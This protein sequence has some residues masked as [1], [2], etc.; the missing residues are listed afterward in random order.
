MEYALG[1]SVV[2]NLGM[3][4]LLYR[5]SKLYTRVT[6]EREDYK[7][8]VHSAEARVDGL[9]NV[10][11]AREE[12]QRRAEEELRERLVDYR[13][14]INRRDERIDKLL[15]QN[16]DMAERVAS[17][18]ASG[19]LPEGGDD[20]FVDEAEEPEPWSEG[21]RKFYDG[22]GHEAQ[23]WAEDFIETRRNMGVEDEQILR[24]LRNR[25][26]L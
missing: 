20:F 17:L 18:R 7:D 4:Y 24:E 22:L 11:Q 3:I 6:D 19:D 26:E 1:L 10:V 25:G 14:A 15:K 16:Q 2:A 5:A 13:E 21:L 9:T 12:T 23:A 8:R